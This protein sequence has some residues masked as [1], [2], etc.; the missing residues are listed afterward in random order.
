MKIGI[1]EGRGD[2]EG[3]VVRRSMM[4]YGLNKQDNGPSE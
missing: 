4:H 1:M 2:G 3:A